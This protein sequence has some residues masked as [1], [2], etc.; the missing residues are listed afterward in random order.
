MR[1]ILHFQERKRW[2]IHA[3]AEDCR[4]RMSPHRDVASKETMLRLF[5]Y[6][7]ATDANIEQVETEIRQWNRGS[8]HLDV[9]G[10]RLHIIGATGRAVARTHL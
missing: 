3:M 6:L 5:R 2:T 1:L 9:P 8:V 7:G 10:D 4:T